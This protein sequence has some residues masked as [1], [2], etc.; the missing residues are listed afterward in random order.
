MCVVCVV[1]MRL[2]PEAHIVI[3]DW[4]EAERRLMA[5]YPLL[6]QSERLKLVAKFFVMKVRCSAHLHG[7]GLLTAL[8]VC[9][10]L[11]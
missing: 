9:Q 10:S 8:R 1:Q 5:P 3:W 7:H 4:F 2:G 11:A 6:P